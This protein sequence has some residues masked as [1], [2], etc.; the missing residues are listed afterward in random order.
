MEGV[1]MRRTP[2]R[3]EV[4]DGRGS[5]VGTAARPLRSLLAYSQSATLLGSGEHC[6]ALSG[7][8]RCPARPATRGSHVL[9]DEVS[10][11]ACGTSMRKDR[12]GTV[13]ELHDRS[14]ER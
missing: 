8:T 11:P 9:V 2:V 7:L 3:N 4:A 13:P 1:R 5:A 6:P 14:E 10:G 12:E